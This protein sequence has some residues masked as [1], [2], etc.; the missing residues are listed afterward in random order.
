[1]GVRDI[2][3]ERCTDSEEGGLE[4]ARGFSL[5]GSLLKHRRLA[6]LKPRAG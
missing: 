2:K 1:M 3:V 6:G 4:A 5:G